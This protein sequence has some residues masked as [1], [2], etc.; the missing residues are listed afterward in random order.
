MSYSEMARRLTTSTW[1]CYPATVEQIEKRHHVPSAVLLVRLANFFRVTLDDLVAEHGTE[2]MKKH[3]AKNRDLARIGA[4]VHRLRTAKGWNLSELARRS[5]TKEWTCYPA[6]IQQ[7]ERA[8]HMPGTHIVKDISRA[9]GVT[10]N[11]LLE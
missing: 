10:V 9:L 11:D 4:N 7:I 3:S 2:S 1:K 8:Q 5:S 6:T